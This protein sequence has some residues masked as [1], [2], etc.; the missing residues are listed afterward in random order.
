MT[1]LACLVVEPDEGMVPGEHL[2][3]EGGVIL[4]RAAARDRAPDLHRLV[5]VD[6]TLLKRVRVRAA[7]EHSQRRRH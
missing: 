2:A 5:Q 6:V 7:G 3:V 4:G 1:H